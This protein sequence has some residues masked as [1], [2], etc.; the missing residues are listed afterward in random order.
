[1][2]HKNQYKMKF[3]GDMDKDPFSWN[4]WI[5]ITGLMIYLFMS[6]WIFCWLYLSIYKIIY[7]SILIWLTL[8]VYSELY[9]G[10]IKLNIVKDG[11]DLEYTLAYIHCT[12]QKSKY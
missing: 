8:S 7:L 6:L 11:Y 12:F 1:M 5:P 3:S 2:F 4:Q 10:E 9:D